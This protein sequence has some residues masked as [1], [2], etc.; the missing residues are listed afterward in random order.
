MCPTTGV[1]PGWASPFH[2]LRARGDG[3]RHAHA[4]RAVSCRG[5]VGTPQPGG[6]RGPS[7]TGRCRL[8]RLPP[9]PLSRPGVGYET[10]P[11]GGWN[12]I[13]PADRCAPFRGDPPGA[14]LGE[15]E[16]R[17]WRRRRR[18]AEKSRRRRLWARQHCTGS[19]PACDARRRGRFG[20][21]CR[22]RF[23]RRDRRNVRPANRPHRYPTL[24]RID[25]D[26]WRPD[27]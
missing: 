2:R 21:S 20:F 12:R 6:A 17:P 14:G 15:P 22:A 18:F 26:F 10:S 3:S 1:L 19:E 4:L 24:S 16:G 9:G 8:R 23:R 5:P 11:V 27:R 7:R 13:S 25:L